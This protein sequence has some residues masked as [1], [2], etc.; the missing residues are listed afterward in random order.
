MEF[1]L[2]AHNFKVTFP[3]NI[4]LHYHNW[5][6]QINTIHVIEGNLPKN[7]VL[8]LKTDLILE[9]FL[10]GR[11]F[12]RLQTFQTK[13]NGGIKPFESRWQTI[14]KPKID[15]HLY[16]YQL[17]FDRETNQIVEKCISNSAPKLF[18][19]LLLKEDGWKEGQSST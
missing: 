18:I 1:I 11:D 15:F 19:E 6:I 5:K 2:T 13:S 12:G 14:T 17:G 7:K 4:D 8:S 16:L 9:E 3:D 10:H